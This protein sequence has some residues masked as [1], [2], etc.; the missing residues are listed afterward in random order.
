MEPKNYN[1]PKP[2]Y[3]PPPPI[4]GSQNPYGPGHPY[5]SGC[6]DPNFRQPQYQG[7]P[8]RPGHVDMRQGRQWQ[9][10]YMAPPQQTNGMGVAGFVLSLVA[11]FGCTVPYLSGPIWLLG[12][13]FS[14][15]GLNRQPRGLAIAGL[16]I[17]LVGIFIILA[18]LF[19]VGAT[20]HAD[21]LIEFI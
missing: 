2:P 10:P 16:I 9:E 14:I 5:G 18:V 1:N 15:I 12:L 11:F 17:S 4:Q 7:Q 19:F 21:E 8:F 13:I 20:F 3:P 6:H